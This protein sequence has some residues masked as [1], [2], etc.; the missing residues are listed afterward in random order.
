M[1]SAVRELAE[2]EAPVGQH[3]ECV[4]KYLEACNSLFELGILSHNI[5]SSSDQRVLQ[6]MKCGFEFFQHWKKD[7]S[8]KFPGM[9]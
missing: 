9:L 7:L 8:Q 3:H 2:K 4:A 6:H 5:V 1:I